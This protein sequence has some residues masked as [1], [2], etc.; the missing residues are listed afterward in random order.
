M[1]APPVPPGPTTVPR[2]SFLKWSAAAGGSAALVATTVRLGGLPGVGP[3]NAAT[4]GQSFDKTVCQGTV[5][6][7]QGRS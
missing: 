1:S 4:A 6:T 3:A 7:A 5:R 2:R